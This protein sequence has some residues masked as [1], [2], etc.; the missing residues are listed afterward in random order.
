[1]GVSSSTQE[2][3]ENTNE[4]FIASPDG[5]VTLNKPGI[6]G[7]FVLIKIDEVEETPEESKQVNEK[8]IVD[9]AGSAFARTDKYR[10]KVTFD[11]SAGFTIELLI[12]VTETDDNWTEES[13]TLQVVLPLRPA[14]TV[15][16][17]FNC[18]LTFTLPI[19][20]DCN[21]T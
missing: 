20:V 15:P 9:R 12:G 10:T 17:I 18:L 16:D 21:E 19:T 8:V 13:L 5:G 7:P 1:M 3:A 4:V 6:G 11:A 2:I 14:T